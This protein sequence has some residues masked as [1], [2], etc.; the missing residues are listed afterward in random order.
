MASFWHPI[1]NSSV[2]TR[3]FDHQSVSKLIASSVLYSNDSILKGQNQF[4]ESIKSSQIMGARSYFSNII[5]S[6]IDSNASYI[7]Y[8]NDLL[9]TIH[10]SSLS[11]IEYSSVFSNQSSVNFIHDSQLESWDSSFVFLNKAFVDSFH[12][13][14]GFFQ[15]SNISLNSA[16]AH[17]V[18][19]S[20]IMLDRS[21]ASQ[22][23][24]SDIQMID[25]VVAHQVNITGTFDSSMILNA[26]NSEGELIDSVVFNVNQGIF[27]GQDV[28]VL[29]GDSHVINANH[30]VSLG[31]GGHTIAA[32]RSLAIGKDISIS[33]DKALLINA[34][35]YSLQSDRDGQLKIQADGGLKIQFSDEMSI[36]MTDAS[37]GSWSTISDRNLKSDQ[38]SVDIYSI[39]DKLK[40]LPIQYWEY[41]SEPTL[42]H[43]GPTA[44]DFYEIFKYG[45]SDKVIHSI[46]SDG[47]LISAIKGLN[48]SVI[49]TSE[50]ISFYEQSLKDN[51]N[52]FSS[53]TGRIDELNTRLTQLDYRFQKYQKMLSNFEKD[54]H[55]QAALIQYMNNTLN[56][57]KFN[58][59]FE[60]LRSGIGLFCLVFV[61]CSLGMGIGRLIIQ[62]KR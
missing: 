17:Y 51:V 62:E 26:K 6:D 43:V 23:E 16:N 5:E 35:D 31:G 42:K 4:V 1:T 28:S 2:L 25:S 57:L 48:E 40:K 39:M 36:A 21:M 27:N 29:G 37:G 54:Q 14:G 15:S 52:S 32:N 41:K 45:N 59:I 33:H 47:V 44:Q 24:S 18:T 49:H 56:R 12:S 9:A 22:I 53:S 3:S 30:H 8:T 19:D 58:M 60:W 13:N 46:D 7:G 50:L 38:V 61:G 55:E 34:S 20:N 10:Q 11:Y